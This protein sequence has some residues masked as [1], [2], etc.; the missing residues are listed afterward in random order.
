MMHSQ[1][2]KVAFTD[3][4]EAPR[5]LV[6]GAYLQVRRDIIEGRLVPGEKLWDWRR[7]AA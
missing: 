2:F 1:K 5:T 4:D 6:E 3:A 7:N